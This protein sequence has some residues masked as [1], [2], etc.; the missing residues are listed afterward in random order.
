M[1]RR[2]RIAKLGIFGDFAIFALPEPFHMPE[3]KIIH[4]IPLAL[5]AALLYVSA[6]DTIGH[7]AKKDPA[8]VSEQFFGLLRKQEYEKAKQ[9]GTEHTRRLLNVA[10]TLSEMGGGINIL[11]DNKKELIGCQMNGDEAVCTYRTFSG[12]DQKVF[13]VKE[14]GRW[15][16]DLRDE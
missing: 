5:L 9:L 4:L 12:P 10:Q 14:K 1:A 11:R 7:G 2:F 8:A 6:C 3:R 13:L 15:L 16:V